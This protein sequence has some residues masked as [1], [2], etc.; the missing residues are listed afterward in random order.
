[1]GYSPWVTK[2]QTQLK[3]L[4]THKLF[5]FCQALGASLHSKE[6][7][8][9]LKNNIHPQNCFSDDKNSWLLQKHWKPRKEQED[10]ENQPQSHCSGRDYLFCFK[11][12]FLLLKSLWLYFWIH[13]LLGNQMSLQAPNRFPTRLLSLSTTSWQVQVQNWIS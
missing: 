3:Q 9:F 10:N 1:M 12:S 7:T 11:N 5:P 8:L 13:V 4:S 6:R 2:R